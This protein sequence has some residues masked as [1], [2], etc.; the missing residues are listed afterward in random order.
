M[1]MQVLNYD[2][3]ARRLHRLD[4]IGDGEIQSRLHSKPRPNL[5][6]GHGPAIDLLTCLQR[7]VKRTKERY[8]AA[9]KDLQNYLETVK[10]G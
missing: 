3:K 5:D 7:E 6:Q 1:G 2:M 9:C 8:D 4:E 10:G